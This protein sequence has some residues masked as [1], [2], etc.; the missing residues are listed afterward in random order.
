MELVLF[1]ILLKKK[2]EVR[3]A[4]LKDRQK[5]VQKKSEA[6]EPKEVQVKVEVKTSLFD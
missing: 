2:K 6:L 1:H 3:D 4:W 5:K